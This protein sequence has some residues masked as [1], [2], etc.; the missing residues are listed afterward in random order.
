MFKRYGCLL[1][2]L[3][4]FVAL[5]G[6]GK[7]TRPL[8]P[9]N[10]EDETTQPDSAVAAENEI[11][12]MVWDADKMSVSLINKQTGKRWGTSPGD[13]EEPEY[14]E[15]GMPIKKHP[16]VESALFVEYMDAQTNTV[17]SVIS[18][19]GAVR[20]GRVCCE[21]LADGLLVKYYFDE[22]ELMVPVE[23]RLRDSGATLTI[24]PQQI[25]EGDNR[26]VRISLAPFW[27]SVSNTEKDGYLLIPSGSGALIYPEE[28]SQSG[29]TY[30]AAVYG[31]DAA[32]EV[33]DDPSEVKSVRLPVYGA[34]SGDKATCAIIENGAESAYIEVKSGATSLGYSA[35]YATFQLRGY[36]DNVSSL[37]NY[38]TVQNAVYADNAIQ[39]PIQVGFYLLEEDE[40]N[41]SA[42]AA[43]YKKYL[44]DT[45]GMPDAASDIRLALNVIGGAMIQKSM[46][47]IPYETLYP[48]TTLK[49]AEEILRDLTEAT[50]VHPAVNLQGYGSAGI[51]IGQLAGGFSIHRKLGSVKELQA[52]ADYCGTD[53]P[54][55]MDFDVIGLAKS[56]NGFSPFF[57]SARSASGKVTY[58]YG[59]NIAVRSRQNSAR[60]ALLSRRKLED[61]IRV[62]LKKTAS[63]ELKGIGISTLSNTAY[64][65]YT[66]EYDSAYHAKGNMAADVADL[67]KT[68]RAE[69]KAILVNDANAYAA[70][71]ADLVLRAPTKSS[72]ADI[73]DEDIPFYEMVFRGH[74]PLTCES[75]NQAP[76]A[77][78]QLLQAVEG[79][80]GLTYT[81]IASYDGALMDVASTAF[82]NSAYDDIRSQIIESMEQL[83]TY[84]QKI[85]GA[86]I[87]RHTILENGLRETVFDNGVSVY[88][89][90][91]QETLVSPDGRVPPVSFQIRENRK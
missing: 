11:Y 1:V 21:E 34:K 65:D 36:T 6:C 49:Q 3:V 91:S 84:Y 44:M 5:T 15:L 67:L 29:R 23:Y 28:Y 54:L 41:Y 32:M 12:R 2:S 73:F 17:N 59:F 38:T 37:P 57:D 43:V 26:I 47:G 71:H 16:Q 82:Y 39:T 86:T 25:Q 56:G 31:E 58:C 70:A 40:A 46:L 83:S 10:T 72:R 78:R 24:D 68:L 14:D 30:S 85:A 4:L 35:V 48:T 19:N 74:V 61:S 7:V 76:D 63:W 33:W 75:I 22:V 53:S 27:C 81:V 87:Q 66:D 9:F 52:L 20:N 8:L 90:Y 80:C 77:A 88:V 45:E 89:N 55:F 42:M 51:E 60:Y 79:G 62:L 18:Y 13:S 69:G 50:G 64:S